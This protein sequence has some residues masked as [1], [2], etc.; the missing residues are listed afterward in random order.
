[1]H[2]SETKRCH[3]CDS[4]IFLGDCNIKASYHIKDGR[5]YCDER[6]A[7]KDLSVDDL[8]LCKEKLIVIFAPKSVIDKDI[9]SSIKEYFNVSRIFPPNN[10]SSWWEKYEK[11]MT[12]D[13]C[14]VIAKNII[15]LVRDGHFPSH[16]ALAQNYNKFKKINNK[17]VITLNLEDYSNKEKN[18]LKRELNKK[19]KILGVRYIEEEFHD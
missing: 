5:L 9:N 14:V 19:Y 8:V 18:S 3:L 16:E 12:T 10:L 4:P 1:M 2:F 15:D 17:I 11:I 7:F 13:N 6:C